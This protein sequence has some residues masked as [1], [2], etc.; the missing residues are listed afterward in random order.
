MDTG[1]GHDLTTPAGADGYNLE[2]IRKIVFST[3]NGRISTNTAISVLS[4]LLRG[5]AD[6][7]VL[8]ET[9]WVLSIGRRVMEMGYSFVWIAKTTPWLVA[10]DGHRIDLEVHGNIPFLRVGNHAEQAMVAKSVPRITPVQVDTEENDDESEDEFCAPAKV[11]HC[12]GCSYANS[13]MTAKGGIIV[14]DSEE[15]GKSAS[16]QSNT[17]DSEQE[18][19]EASNTDADE[20]LEESEE[21]DVELRSRALPSAE[22]QKVVPKD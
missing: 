15:E 12:P 11:K 16:E 19:S 3:A 5:P 10:P 9:P 2:K 22:D 14:L 13:A 20:S 4:T 17:S 7:Y 18:D 6:P 1:S 21:G 8:P